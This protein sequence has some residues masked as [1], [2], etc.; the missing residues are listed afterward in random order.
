M[1]IPSD[2]QPSPSLIRTKMISN[3]LPRPITISAS[4]LSALQDYSQVS[5][6]KIRRT[7][8]FGGAP[9]I[10]LNIPEVETKHPG[11]RWVVLFFACALL[12]GNYYAY[13]SP[14]ALNVPLGKYLQVDYE[15]WLLSF[16]LI[17]SMS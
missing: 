16:N 9:L 17:G 12:F 5:T 8:S 1:P 14:A 7:S 6:R 15:T 10:E 2:S 4:S 11:Q 13:D 3:Y